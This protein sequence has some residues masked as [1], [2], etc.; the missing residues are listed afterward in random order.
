MPI[1]KNLLL[2]ILSMDSYNRGYGAGISDGGEN[3]SD[4]LGKSGFIGS[5]I[6]V[7]RSN[8]IDYQEWQD[9]GFYSIAYDTDYG[10]VISYR[11][12]DNAS[13]LCGFLEACPVGELIFTDIPIA[14]NDDF[15]EPSIHLAS[16]F[17]QGVL[18]ASDSE[19]AIMRLTA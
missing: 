19:L 18:G 12:T 14:R 10:T 7:A 8:D 16:Q 11:G 15:D 1:S 9:A 13:D 17:Y 3:D 4:G 5:A 6:I 2:A